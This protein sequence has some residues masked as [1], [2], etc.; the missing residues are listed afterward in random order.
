MTHL[1]P[2]LSPSERVAL[3]VSDLYARGWSLAWR[4]GTTSYANPI[5]R[6]VVLALRTRDALELAAVLAHESAHVRWFGGYVAGLLRG[7]TYLV[8]PWVR[9]EQEVEA[10]AHACAVWLAAGIDPDYSAGTLAGWRWPYLTGHSAAGIERR[11][12]ER[13]GGIHAEATR[14]A[15]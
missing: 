5:T 6:R 4:E 15:G 7:L 10:R 12:R 2:H 8:S 1:A 14:A 9:V 13:A 11:V 3:L